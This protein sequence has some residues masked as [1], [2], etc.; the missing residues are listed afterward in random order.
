VYNFNPFE[1]LTKM[2]L[3]E[4]VGNDLEPLTGVR[5]DWTGGSPDYVSRVGDHIIH[6]FAKDHHPDVLLMPGEII[7]EFLVGLR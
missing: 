7:N 3:A 2:F 5:E 6:Q 4:G 1:V